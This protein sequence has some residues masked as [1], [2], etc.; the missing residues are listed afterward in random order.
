[1][2][3]RIKFKNFR[4]FTNWTEL[5]IKPL[6]VLVGPNSA[7]KSSI[8]S[9]IKLCQFSDEKL[10]KYIDIISRAKPFNKKSHL[11]NIQFEL[12][13]HWVDNVEDE[14]IDDIDNLDL[15]N[16]NSDS[17]NVKW[18]TLNIELQIRFPRE[19]RV[20][21]RLRK[22]N[23][24]IQKICLRD[25][26]TN[27]DIQIKNKKIESVNYYFT[28]NWLNELQHFPEEL[29]STIN[30]KI[31][32][33][34]LK[35]AYQKLVEIAKK[36][37]SLSS[38]PSRRVNIL[39]PFE[40]LGSNIPDIIGPVLDIRSLS[41]LN[42]F[43]FIQELPLD[44]EYINKYVYDPF[45]IVLDER[46]YN[47]RLRYDF[48]RIVETLPESE[49]NQIFN[50]FEPYFEE[51]KHISFN[52]N[53]NFLYFINSTHAINKTRE[54]LTILLKYLPK[55]ESIKHSE[56]IVNFFVVHYISNIL[57]H[58]IIET[59]WKISD[60]LKGISL[61]IGH[62]LDITHLP[63]FR[64]YFVKNYTFQEK[65]MEFL[66]NQVNA[67]SLEKNIN[68]WM[69]KFEIPYT[70]HLIVH[71]L[72]SKNIIVEHFLRDKKTNK[73][74]SFSEVGFGISQLLPIIIEINRDWLFRNNKIYLIEQPESQLHPKLQSL[75]TDLFKEPLNII[76]QYKSIYNPRFIVETHSEYFIRRLQVLIA[77]K[78]IDVN[79]ISIYYVDKDDQRGSYVTRMEL[80]E[81]GQLLTP[82]P[83][84]FFD[85]SYKHAM[86][87]L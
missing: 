87:L 35:F 44:A 48:K 84:G 74:F 45:V 32:I 14:N 64:E 38:I 43:M 85:E 36:H 20:K 47:K 26:L 10:S 7:G 57:I 39:N 11:L 58:K 40:S 24:L 63:A 61:E 1:M 79:D 23:N 67:R 6:T 65:P 33:R 75:L 72:A 77:K 82:W 78:E 17:N 16:E 15:S 83:S 55:L 9:L 76:R 73:P 71:Q 86:D 31:L 4:N 49:R 70:Y 42:N 5:D 29:I 56:H 22:E 21:T 37:L 2:L 80:S 19:R 30:D 66:P 52:S 13:Y 25:S 28:S 59:T 68:E 53:N 41:D 18:E 3:T 62:S 81:D 12:E 27:F 8:L 60:N 50:I 34:K 46:E 51:C 54:Y 69:E